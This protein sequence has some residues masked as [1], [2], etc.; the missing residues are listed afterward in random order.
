MAEPFAPRPPRV[1]VTNVETG[2]FVQ[3]Q[4]NPDELKEKLGANYREL[5]VQGLPH[6]PLQYTGT[7][8]HELSFILGFDA[9]S[10][11]GGNPDFARRFMQSL[12]YPPAGAQGV[13]DAGPPRALFSWPNLIGLVCRV[14]ALDFDHKRFNLAMKSA[15][16]TV[17]VKLAEDRR[18]R[19]TSDDVLSYGTLRA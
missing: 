14:T 1:T 8:N 17:E 18:D 11:Y 19:L 10:A 3:A 6:R 4:F 12:L 7:G 5:E 2:V 15:L 13:S 9:L 16:W